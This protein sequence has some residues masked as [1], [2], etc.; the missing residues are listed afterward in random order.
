MPVLLRRTL[1]SL[2]LLALLLLLTG[3][4]WV[5]CNGRWADDPPTP[6]PPSL[7]PRVVS[8]APAGNGFFDLLGLR[9][10][11]GSRP[12]E[13][14]QRIWQGELPSEAGAELA[15]PTAPLWK[16]RPEA[17]N[18]VVRWREQA[19]SLQAERAATAAFGQRCRD[20]L[21]TPGYEEPL[22]ELP[23]SGPLARQPIEQSPLPAYAPLGQCLRGFQLEA[24]LATRPADAEAA[25]AQAHALLQRLAAGSQSLLGQ[26]VSW[27]WAKRHALLL[28]QW[29]AA[30]GGG[31]VAPA[32]RAPLPVDV[33]QPRRWMVAEAHFGRQIAQS[34]LS[35]GDV[36]YSSEPGLMQ[37][38]ASRLSLGFLPHATQRL[39]DDIWLDRLHAL[40]T[41]H[42][43]AL[44]RAAEALPPPDTP[45]WTTLRW[46]N[47]VG[48]LLAG[49]AASADYRDMLLRQADLVLFQQALPLALALNDVPAADRAAWLARQSLPADLA[50]RVSLA[51]DALVLR[52]WQSVASSG[53]IEPVRFALRPS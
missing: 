28:A 47:P 10:A 4:A 23:T 39:V 40:G 12:N 38:Q 24:V 44:A 35:P 11:A 50:D 49:F 37:A 52:T 19:L 17:E 3:A 16:C 42:G 13:I 15:M 46:K 48:R 14:G 7:E 25:W 34:M 29:A 5:A 31:V 30:P 32:L 6:R 51:P 43:A 2:A 1:K 26:A 53:P 20:W 21:Q 45:G 22:R 33:M 18:C 27:T 36:L 9:A 41:L 8:L